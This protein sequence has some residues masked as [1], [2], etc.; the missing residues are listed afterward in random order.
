MRAGYTL[1]TFAEAKEI[2]DKEE[3]VIIDVREEE[4]YIT[5]HA[6]GAELFP[7]DDINENSAAEIIP[8]KDMPVMV[9]CRTGSR[10]AL[11]AQK[12]CALGYKRIYDMGSLVGWPYGIVY[13]W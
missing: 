9:Y 5:G 8:S 11:A 12:L 6:D 2:I 4:E 7:V 3:C 1:V 10:S 13:G